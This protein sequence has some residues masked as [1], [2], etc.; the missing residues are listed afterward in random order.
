MQ[1][2]V[3]CVASWDF[4][5]IMRDCIISVGLCNNCN[6]YCE[7]DTQSELFNLQKYNNIIIIYL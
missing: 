3:S 2:F 6:S 4:G 7:F 5:S 1:K